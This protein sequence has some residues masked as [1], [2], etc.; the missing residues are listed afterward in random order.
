[1][2]YILKTVMSIHA[3][4]DFRIHTLASTSKSFDETTWGIPRSLH[5]EV[6]DRFFD[7]M[8]FR[9]EMVRFF[10]TQANLR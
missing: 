2:G 5:L 9:W 8:E 4:V 7:S 6:S 1:M 10:K 3:T